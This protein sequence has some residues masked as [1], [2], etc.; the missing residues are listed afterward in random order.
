MKQKSSRRLRLAFMGTPDFAVGALDGR[1]AAPAGQ[2][3]GVD[4]DA[5]VFRRVENFLR[6]DQPVGGDDG[7]V[8]IQRREFRARGGVFF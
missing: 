4:V 5:A 3:R 6:Q 2:Q 8:E 7:G 1:C